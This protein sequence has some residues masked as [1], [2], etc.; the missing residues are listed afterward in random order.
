MTPLDHAVYGLLWLGFGLGH[1]LMADARVKARLAP[2]FGP[3]YRLAYNLIALVHVAAVWAIGRFILADTVAPFDRPVW[4][5]GLQWALVAAGLAILLLGMRGYDGARFMG[6]AQLR[7]AAMDDGAERLRTTGLNA[8]VR[9][10]LY[11]G[12]IVLL[13]GLIADSF[14]AATAVWAILYLWLGAWAEERRLLARYGEAYA[15]YRERTPML[16]PLPRRSSR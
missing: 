15:A 12:A 11:F 10:P 14:S 4:L 2:V 16:L 13:L 1:S 3:A 6:A 9:H 5:I 7:G 8:H